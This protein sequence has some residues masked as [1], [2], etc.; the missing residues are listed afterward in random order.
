VFNV[1]AGCTD[2]HAK[3]YSLLLDGNS[4]RLAPLYDLVSYAAYWD[5]ESP[6]YSSMSIDG[7]YSLQKI[8]Q[9]Q[10]IASGKLFGLEA[11]AEE[12]VLETA[13]G[14]VGAFSDSRDELLNGYPEARSI[15]DTLVFHVEK[16]PL[17]S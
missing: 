7:E 15:A 2:A 3:N 1:I 10:L 9:S 8:S 12:I 5:G 11:E 4:V 6:I 16:L 17:V 14:M 13:A